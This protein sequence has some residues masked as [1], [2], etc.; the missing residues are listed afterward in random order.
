MTS[1]ISG[2][3]FLDDAKLLYAGQR[4]TPKPTKSTGE[5]APSSASTITDVVQI[6][7]AA[8]AAL[9][10]PLDDTQAPQ[11]SLK[12]RVD[13]LFQD[14]KDRGSFITFDASKGGEW[15]DMSSFT[16][17]ELAQIYNDK[18]GEFSKDVSVHAGGALAF[19]MKVAL[20]PFEN[21]VDSGDRRGQAM[22]IN[23]LYDQMSPAVRQALGW[24]PVMMV[25][26][27][28]MLDG[29]TKFFGPFDESTVITN[30]LNASK[31]GGLSFSP[32]ATRPGLGS[33]NLYA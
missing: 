6:S 20:E 14:A 23:L 17:D 32:P 11:P 24:T 5:A 31:R 1:T 27:N 7:D 9:A 33:F 21:A 8:K 19:R 29:D 2:Y 3:A 30:L 18:S 15:M 4:S 28:E 25:A 16:D 26:N 12:A 22:A 13:K 10:N